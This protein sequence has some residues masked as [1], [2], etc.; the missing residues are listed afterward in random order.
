MMK[1]D[2]FKASFSSLKIYKQHLA[3]SNGLQRIAT[4]CGGLQRISATIKSDVPG[5][6]KGRKRPLLLIASGN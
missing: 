1:N 6:L 2:I 5:R 3:D 4:D